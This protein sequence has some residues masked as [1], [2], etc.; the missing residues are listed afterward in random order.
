MT[1]VAADLE[2][3]CGD[4][5]PLGL[6]VKALN[7][8]MRCRITPKNK[9]ALLAIGNNLGG[10]AAAF[11]SERWFIGRDGKRER[12]PLKKNLERR[13]MK[14]REVLVLIG[15]LDR[16]ERGELLLDRKSV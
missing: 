15:D 5:S 2:L 13:R 14:I 11:T 4:L 12:L 10:D 16:K 6:R 3:F 1:R 9:D 8:V 7:G